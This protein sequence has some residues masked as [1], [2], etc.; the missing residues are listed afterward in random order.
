MVSLKELKTRLGRMAQFRNDELKRALEGL[1]N[2]LRLQSPKTRVRSDRQRLD[3]YSRRSLI[4]FFHQMQL[5]R[6]HLLSL[7]QRL[8]SLNPQSILNRGYAIVTLNKGKVIRT[9]KQVSK[10]DPI[11]VQVSDGQFGAKVDGN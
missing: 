5:H 4:S 2:R 3:E 7:T 9:V 1:A 10:G 8:A 6:A 11:S